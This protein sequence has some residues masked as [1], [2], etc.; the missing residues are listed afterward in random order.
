MNIKGHWRYL[1]YVLRHKWYVFRAMLWMG[2]PVWRAV[3][4]DWTKFTPAEWSPYVNRFYGLHPY[5]PEAGSAGYR[6][7]MGVDKAFDAA[8]R[9]HWM[10]NPHHPEHWSRMHPRIDRYFRGMGLPEEVAL[11][12]PRTY[13]REM[14]CD[15]YGA[16]MAQGKPDI[17]AWFEQ[18]Q[19]RLPLHP[20]TLIRANITLAE[21]EFYLRKR[22][23]FM[24][25]R[26]KA[27]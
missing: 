8:W 4:H 7:M 14:V 18:N 9:H 1:R 6:H 11:K 21:L 17:R 10:R 2:L 19:D 25:S 24:W 15:W 23:P 5:R 22:H 13:L 20:D 12:M 27:K 26:E 16:G 3:V